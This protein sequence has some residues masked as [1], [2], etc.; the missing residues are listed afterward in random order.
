M[1]KSVLAV[2]SMVLVLTMMLSLFGAYSFYAADEAEAAQ[3]VLPDSVDLSA[4]EYFPPVGSQGGLGSCA[5]YASIYYQLTY[6]MNKARGVA[7]TEETTMSPKLIYHL[8]QE[9]KKN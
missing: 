4:T 9:A 5:T 2:I 6:E 8:Y 3:V 7:A 1:R